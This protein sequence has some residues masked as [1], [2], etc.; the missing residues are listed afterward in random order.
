MLIWKELRSECWRGA[1]WQD[2]EQVYVL[3]KARQ[4]AEQQGSGAVVVKGGRKGLEEETTS[5]LL[6]LTVH[7]LNEDLFSK[8]MKLMF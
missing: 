3:W 4:V 2:A 6:D 5:A 8:L 1:W 7:G